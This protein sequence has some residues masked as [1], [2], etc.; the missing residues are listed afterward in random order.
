[1]DLSVLSVTRLPGVGPKQA[2]KFAR[3]QIKTVQDVLF[4]LPLRYQDRTRELAIADLTPGTEVVCSGVV[5]SS[6][7]VFRRRRSLICRISDGSGTLCLRFFNFNKQQQAALREGVR[8][9]CFG[10]IRRGPQSLE[11]VHPEYRQVLDGQSVSVEQTLTPVYPVTEGLHQ[12]SMRKVTSAALDYLQK[13]EISE[14]LPESHGYAISLKQALFTVHRPP[15]DVRVD[16]LLQGQHPCV[17]RLALEELVAHR[18]SVQRVRAHARLQRAPAM[19]GS[20]ELRSKLLRSLPFELTGAQQRVIGEIEADLASVEPMLRLVQ[21]DVGS[22]KTL[23]AAAAA[24]IA[25]DSGYQVAVMAPTEILAEQHLLGFA[26]LFEPLGLKIGWLK[27]KLGARQKRDSLESIALGHTHIAI[28]TH[29]L[30]QKDV[31]FSRLGLT[32]VDEQHR[33]GV[34]QRLSLREKGLS[35]GLVPHQLTMTATPIPR[36]LAMTAYADLD[37]S[38]IDELPPGRQAITTVAVPSTRRREVIERVA[39]AIGEGRQV[40]WVC[41][42]IEESEVLQA[43]AAEDTLNEL[44]ELLT[45]VSISLVHGRMS[46]PEK[47]QAM[48]AFKNNE[49]QLLVATTVIEVGVDVPNASLIIIEN[50]ERLGLSQLHQ[51][52]G[53]VGRGKIQSSCVLMYEAGLSNRARDRIAIMRESTDGFVIAERDLQLR[54]AGELLGTRQT[55]SMQFRIAD[56]MRDKHL[57]EPARQLSEN[58]Q[59]TN[60]DNAQLLVNRWMGDNTPDYGNV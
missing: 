41:T 21:G 3:L 19:Q 39:C 48:T 22:G 15:P 47:D 52:R 54:G 18:L 14:L 8:I 17:Q 12:L 50:V 53:R 56:I 43:R 33:F 40:Y 44:A 2:E 27:G 24:A 30:F 46:G 1:M 6:E 26:E 11:I 58:I 35:A 36:T 37:C 4:H 28:G 57:L 51:L 59:K 5:M 9:R 13:T 16:E 49:T 38:V 29:A 45:D 31:S 7:V 25:V 10:E 42:L 34:D 23:V 55:G 60:A 32:I 20:N